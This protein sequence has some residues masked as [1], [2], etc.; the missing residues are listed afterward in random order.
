M[1]CG[2]GGSQ[3]GTR[4]A[5]TSNATVTRYEVRLRDGTVTVVEGQSEAQKMLRRGGGGTM[6]RVA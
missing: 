4:G 2:C 6:K 1:G 3:V 5:T